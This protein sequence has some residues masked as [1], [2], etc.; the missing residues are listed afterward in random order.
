MRTLGLF[1]VIN[2]MKDTFNLIDLRVELLKWKRCCHTK[3]ESIL[4]RSCVFIY[5]RFICYL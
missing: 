3:Q 5:N 4:H 1:Q 2:K